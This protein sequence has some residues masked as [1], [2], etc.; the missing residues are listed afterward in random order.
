MKVSN[1]HKMY[2]KK[3]NDKI[4]FKTSITRKNKKKQ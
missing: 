1:E 4:A 2:I 3:H